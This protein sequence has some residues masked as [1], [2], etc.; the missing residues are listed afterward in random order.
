MSDSVYEALIDHMVPWRHSDDG[1]RRKGAAGAIDYKVQLSV[2]SDNPNTDYRR[3]LGTLR[4]EDPWVAVEAM[5][6]E[7]S[8]VTR[9]TFPPGVSTTMLFVFAVA[10]V[11]W[12]GT[13]APR[14]PR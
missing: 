13:S 8:R 2:Q 1:V 11:D 9:G 3:E 14:R 10:Y 4:D 7:G 12:G 6:L 5:L